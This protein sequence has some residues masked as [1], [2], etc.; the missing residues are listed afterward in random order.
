MEMKKAKVD[1][2]KREKT[3]AESGVDLFAHHTACGLEKKGDKIL[4]VEARE[5]TGGR[6]KRFRAPV[7]IDAT[8]DGWLGY[9]AGADYRYG[10]EAAS[11]HDEGWDNMV[12]CGVRRKRITGSWEQVFYGIASEPTK[13]RISPRF[14]GPYRCPVNMSASKGEWY[15]GIF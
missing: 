11:Q 7:F 6:I 2:V 8:G 5:V 9:W 13:N 12:I 14:H 3:M 4:S 15:L 1:Q 10:R